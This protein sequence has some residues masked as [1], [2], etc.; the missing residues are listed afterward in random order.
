MDDLCWVA[1]LEILMVIFGDL[2]WVGY[3]HYVFVGFVFGLEDDVCVCQ[4]QVVVMDD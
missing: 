2:F 4:D 3:D 1:V